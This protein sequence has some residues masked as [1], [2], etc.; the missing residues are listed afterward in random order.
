MGKINEK[1]MKI[2]G[3]NYYFGVFVVCMT[4]RYDSFRG[5]CFSCS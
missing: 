1:E 3:C 4:I 2:L 5:K